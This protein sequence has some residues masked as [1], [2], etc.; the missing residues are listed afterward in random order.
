MATPCLQSLRVILLGI[1]VA[2]IDPCCSAAVWS[3]AKK[4]NPWV[5]EE[6][7][8]PLHALH[9]SRA[10]CIS[11]LQQDY[12][13]TVLPICTG[14]LTSRASRNS[15]GN[16]VSRCVFFLC[17][18]CHR[19]SCGPRTLRRDHC[20]VNR[21]SGRQRLPVFLAEHRC[22]QH[23]IARNALGDPVAFSTH[24]LSVQ[25]FVKTGQ[26]RPSGPSR[27]DSGV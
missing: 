3:L 19:G 1:Q 24:Q 5:W 23:G 4:K 9:D 10:V 8:F 16:D 22:T 2:F 21:T 11:S 14:L 7:N 26:M 18:T 17:V 15:P 27:T 6:K 12:R 25:P 13:A 20:I